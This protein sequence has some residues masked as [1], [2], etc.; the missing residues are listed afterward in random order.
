MAHKITFWNYDLNSMCY[1]HLEYDE[2]TLMAV[3]EPDYAYDT[4]TPVNLSLLVAPNGVVIADV[5]TYERSLN[6]TS[7][8]A[9]MPPGY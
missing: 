3:K 6:I 9:E 2:Y 7:W 8:E 1:S 5:E 4:K